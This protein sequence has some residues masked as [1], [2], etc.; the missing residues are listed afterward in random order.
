[1]GLP[2]TASADMSCPSGK[3]VSLIIF[4]QHAMSM[5]MVQPTNMTALSKKV[6]VWTSWDTKQNEVTSSACTVFFFRQQKT[7]TSRENTAGLKLKACQKSEIRNVNF[8]LYIT[9]LELHHL[10]QLLF[11]SILPER[12]RRQRGLNSWLRFSCW[13]IHI[14]MSGAEAASQSR[15]DKNALTL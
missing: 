3:G 13:I 12:C 6:W 11:Y 8:V 2:S 9:C 7:L 15:S 1:M 10:N 5:S 14:A 4:Q